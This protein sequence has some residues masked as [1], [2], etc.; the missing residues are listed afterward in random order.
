MIENIGRFYISIGIALVVALIA[1]F[2][3][4]KTFELGLDLQGGTRYVFAFDFEKERELGNIGPNESP[5]QVIRETIDIISTRADP[6]GVREPIIR[7][8]GF[9][10]VVVELPG[11]TNT[12]VTAPPST[13]QEP[14]DASASIEQIVIDAATASPFPIGGGKIEI[15]GEKIRYD[16]RGGAQGNVLSGIRRGEESTTPTQHAAGAP[17]RLVSADAILNAIQNLGDLSFEIVLDD[18]TYLS[19]SGTD[20]TLER[21]KLETWLT[22]NPG[23]DLREFNALSAQ[24]GGPNERLRWLPD[25]RSDVSDTRTLLQRAV[26]LLRTENHPDFADKDWR[27]DGQKLA[28][29]YPSPDPSQMSSDWVVNFEFDSA[30]HASFG[31]FTETFLERRMAVN[32]NGQ[33][34]VAP[35]INKAIYGVGFIEGR[36][37]YEEAQSLVTVLR[38]GSLRLKPELLAE[39]RVGPTLGAEYVARGGYSGA[40]ALAGVLVFMA[41][42]YR[43]LGMFAVVSLLANMV[44]LMGGLAFLRPAITLPGIAGIILTIGM[45]VD[46]N[47]LIF[48]RIRE[49]RDN[50]RNVKQAAK[51]GFD[52]AFSAILDA[53]V[54]TFLTAMILKFVATGPVRGFANTLSIGIITSVFSALVVTRVLVHRSL[55]SG[56][57]DFKVGT[58]MVEAA[59]DWMAKRKV[60]LGLSIT[61]VTVSLLIFLAAPRA[62]KYGIDFLGGATVQFRTDSPQT[63]EAI[64]TAVAALPGYVSGATIKPVV[65]SSTDGRYTEFRAVFKVDPDMVDADGGAEQEFKAEIETGLVDLLQ[66]GPIDLELV[67]ADNLGVDLHLYFGE[68]HPAADVAAALTLAGI[69]DPQVAEDPTRPDTFEVT[70]RIAAGSDT[71]GLMLSIEQ[72]FVG[73]QDSTGLGYTMPV[74]VSDSSLVGAQVVGDLRDKAILALLV[75]LFAIVM[76]IRVRFADYAYGFAAVT[77]LIHDVTITLGMLVLA[78]W[79]GLISAEIDLPMIAAF[80]TI[81]GYSLNDT[82]VVFDRVRENIPRVEG[83]LGDV[84]NKSINQTLSRTILTSATTLMAV[85][86]LFAF[87]V[88]T[89]NTLEGFSFA[90]ACGVFVGTYSS[91]FIASPLL[92]FFEDYADKRAAKHAERERLEGGRSAAKVT[93]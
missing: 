23:G 52:K 47:I 21:K 84:L 6:D 3:P 49:E 18:N 79:V 61:A 74:A 2:A 20:L 70:G 5:Q 90:M 29:A 58:W 50:G 35:N 37:K 46:A 11:T 12:E 64:R 91:I 16:S 7:Q 48:D 38:S 88:G 56:T 86:V 33:V 62:T 65:S 59:Y 15:A 1:L 30:Y 40:L 63:P 80:L 24:D 13:L 54:T 82:I 9:D 57:K 75:S 66:K 43:R 73:Q 93:S 17:V 19:G 77:A 83:S 10:R 53:N 67:G 60:A 44:F 87:N 42:Y 26:P 45:A 69:V 25:K 31:A 39:E 55:E 14:I 76:Y 41:W 72:A 85:L 27:F 71:T 81:I 4:A 8:E 68:G 34:E 89:G 36:Y 28:R 32:L 51:N 92:L 78:N 22:A